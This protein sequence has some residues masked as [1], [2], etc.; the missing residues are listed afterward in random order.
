MII[1][2]VLVW[3]VRERYFVL[4]LADS[5]VF[6]SSFPWLYPLHKLFRQPEFI[7]AGFSVLRFFSFRIGFNTAVLGCV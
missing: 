6:C 4:L 2:G 3:N 5:P 1:E 7:A